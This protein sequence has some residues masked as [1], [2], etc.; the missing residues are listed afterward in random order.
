MEIF[1]A[2]TPYKDTDL[3]KFVALR[4]LEL[5]PKS[6]TDIAAEAGFPNANFVSM[7]KSGTSKLA[8]D[9]VPSFAKALECDPAFLMRLALEQSVGST[10]AKAL[11]DILGTPTTAN[12]RLWLEE[13]R[14]ASDNSDPRPASRA[15]AAIRGVFGK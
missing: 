15:R 12:E 2:T 5:R 14:N 8:L 4:I 7:I 1:V 6:Q 9:R 13:I 11:V 10:A 3:A